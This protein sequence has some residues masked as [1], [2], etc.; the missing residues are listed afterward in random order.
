[1]RRGAE[2]NRTDL[3]DK[4][5]LL[6]GAIPHQNEPRKPQ[7]PIGVLDHTDDSLRRRL[8]IRRDLD[9]RLDVYLQQR[10]KGISRSRIQKLIDMGGVTVNGL[11]PKA[12][13]TVRRGDCV[14]ILLPP[15]AIR[16][17]EPEPIPL[18]VIY[19]DDWIIVIN[20]QR[21]LIVH[22]ARSH[23]SGT[24]LN[25]LAYRFQQQQDHAGQPSLHRTTRG[26]S[27]YDRP[28]SVTGCVTGLSRVGATEF[29]PGI[30]H[31]L[32]KDT[33]GVLVVAKTDEGHWAIAKQFASRSTVKAYL[34][35]VHGDLDG[36]GGVID[37]PIG[38]HPTIRQ[39]QAIRHDSAGKPSVTLYR[40]RERYAGYSLVELE[41]KT[42]RTHQIR[43]HMSYVGHPIVGDILYGGEPIGESE[44]D[45]PP[46]A[47][48]SRRYLTFAR[49]RSEGQRLSAI[50]EARDDL[51][52]GHP[53]LHAALLRFTHP[54][55]QQ[56]VT[57]TAPVHQTMIRLID[58]LRRRRVDGPVADKGYWVDLGQA[59]PVDA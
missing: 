19:E 14:E 11:A 7:A 2:S 4:T 17:I 48:G 3:S 15:R 41:L 29:R 5:D 33:T 43:V 28:A 38:K 51:V 42:G 1:M 55:T 23:L 16:T 18:E 34:A 37:Q 10:L 13:T 39:A 24:L 36:V 25:G 27:L 31:R 44:L 26:F 46:L 40:V 45:R 6:A 22:P 59:V 35:V 53:A 58:A 32:D 12:S 8:I 52:M 49:R 30:V 57:F 20:K 50:S 21:N 47:A 56:L 54:H 9:R